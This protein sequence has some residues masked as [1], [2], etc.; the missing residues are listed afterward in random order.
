MALG[1]RPRNAGSKLHPIYGLKKNQTQRQTGN[2]LLQDSYR[3][4]MAGYQLTKAEWII[5]ISNLPDESLPSKRLY[6]EAPMMFGALRLDA[7]N[8]VG[9]DVKL[10]IKDRPVI[11]G[12][13]NRQA[14]NS[15]PTN[16]NFSMT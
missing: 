15:S 7:A 5:Y 13:G 11:H 14:S 4:E 2:L 3:K 8:A 6:A 9:E 10:M 16:V 1:P 12:A